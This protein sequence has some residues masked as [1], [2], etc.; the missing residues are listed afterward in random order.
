MR[1]GKLRLSLGIF[2]A[3]ILSSIVL[4]GCKTVPLQP[5]EGADYK[6]VGDYL[7]FTEAY[8]EEIM[9]VRIKNG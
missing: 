4:T 2:L 7:C 1:K 6:V 9:K 3:L 8:V 5:V